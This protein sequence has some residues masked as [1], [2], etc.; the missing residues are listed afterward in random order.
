MQASTASSTYGHRNLEL[1]RRHRQRE[2]AIA[3]MRLAATIARAQAQAAS[4]ACEFAIASCN[5]LPLMSHAG[6]EGKAAP[7]QPHSNLGADGKTPAPCSHHSA[8]GTPSLPQMHNS[9]DRE[10]PHCRHHRRHQCEWHRSRKTS[11]SSQM[12]IPIDA[13]RPSNEPRHPR[14][15]GPHREPPRQQRSMEHRSPHL[16]TPECLDPLAWSGLV[17]LGQEA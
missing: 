1:E 16:R 3:E 12:P 13:R 11:P 8:C 6:D 5:A 14:T 10:A 9:I 17:V 4:D 15:L 2:Q 7:G